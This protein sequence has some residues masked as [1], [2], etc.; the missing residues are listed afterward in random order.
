MRWYMSN[1]DSY[2]LLSKYIIYRKSCN[3]I[4]ST[5]FRIFHIRPNFDSWIF[6]QRVSLLFVYAGQTLPLLFRPNQRNA[7][8]TL[9]VNIEL[10]YCGTRSECKCWGCDKSLAALSSIFSLVLRKLECFAKIQNVSCFKN[11]EVIV[12]LNFIFFMFLSSCLLLFVIS[13]YLSVLF[14]NRVEIVQIRD[15][16][17]V[18]QPCYVY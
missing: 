5:L 17:K 14:V 12:C 10:E 4:F 2:W 18:V 8:M 7:R 9:V 11:F 15:V 6:H 13:G 16:I 1:A 3:V